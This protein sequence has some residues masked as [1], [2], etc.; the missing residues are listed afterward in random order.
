MREN[1]GECHDDV[2]AGGVAGGG[3]VIHGHVVGS[4]DCVNGTDAI[5]NGACGT[6]GVLCLL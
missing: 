4:G 3:S 1:C 2:G 5:S 6:G